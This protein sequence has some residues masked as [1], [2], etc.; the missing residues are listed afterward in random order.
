MADSGTFFVCVVERGVFGYGRMLDDGPCGIRRRQF[1]T[2]VGNDDGTGFSDDRSV[3]G[4][5]QFTAVVG[6]NDGWRG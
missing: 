4:R 1:T 3:T 6:K 5:R 2:V